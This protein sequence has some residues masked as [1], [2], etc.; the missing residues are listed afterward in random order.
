MFKH[1]N[2]TTIESS[3]T[4]SN[5]S[6]FNNMFLNN[7]YTSKELSIIYGESKRV[8]EQRMNKLLDKAFLL[9]ILEQLNA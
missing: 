2:K 3:D 1:A 4:E 7:N 9:M 8:T 6:I 5:I